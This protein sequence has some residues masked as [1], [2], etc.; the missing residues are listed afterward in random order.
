M[1]FI[2]QIPRSSSAKYYSRNAA[3]SHVCRRRDTLCAL[4]MGLQP[5]AR[6]VVVG[7]PRQHFKIGYSLKIAQIFRLL[8]ISPIIIIIIILC[9]VGEP[10]DNNG[11]SPVS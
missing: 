6:K 9:A 8:G 1:F 4:S 3:C 5:A 7:R 10:T 11:C 2:Y